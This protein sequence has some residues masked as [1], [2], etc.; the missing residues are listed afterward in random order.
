[1]SS[2]I[3]NQKTGASV[4]LNQSSEERFGELLMLSFGPQMR[5]Q[6]FHQS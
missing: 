3:Y 6:T 5:I 2:N 4:E 1:M